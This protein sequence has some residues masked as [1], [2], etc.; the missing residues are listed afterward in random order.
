M[1]FQVHHVGGRSG[2]GVRK[3]QGSL[4]V[5]IGSLWSLSVPFPIGPISVRLFPPGLQGRQCSQLNAQNRGR[6]GRRCGEGAGGGCSPNM[7]QQALTSLFRAAP[8]TNPSP[9]VGFGAVQLPI[10][11]LLVVPASPAVSMP[12]RL[13]DLLN[14]L[15]GPC[16]RHAGTTGVSSF[17]RS[18][19]SQVLGSIVATC[20]HGATVVGGQAVGAVIT[21]SEQAHD[22]T[23]LQPTLSIFRC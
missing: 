16:F 19:S 1:S 15:Y 9:A 2:R 21:C 7:G 8:K 22:R 12:S 23:I 11:M 17:G 5:P 3:L 13:M 4:S 20:S 14:S 10:E 6:A 18:A